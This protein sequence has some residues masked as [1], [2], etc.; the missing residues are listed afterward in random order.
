MEGFIILIVYIIFVSSC[1][2]ETR[3]F[4][5]FFKGYHVNFIQAAQ[6]GDQVYVAIS[7]D[8][9]LNQMEIVPEPRKSPQLIH[10]PFLL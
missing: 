9:V 3:D 8:Y 1:N 6:Y 10:V 4:T 7:S 5:D 2:N